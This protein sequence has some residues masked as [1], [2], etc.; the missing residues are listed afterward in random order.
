MAQDKPGSR[1]LL[2]QTGADAAAQGSGEQKPEAF[3]VSARGETEEAVVVRRWKPAETGGEGVIAEV[4]GA[5]KEKEHGQR[6][7]YQRVCVNSEKK[8]KNYRILKK[9]SRNW[10]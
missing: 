5:R 6:T 4:I 2:R 1:L 9:V 8:H 7:M 3:V 10:K